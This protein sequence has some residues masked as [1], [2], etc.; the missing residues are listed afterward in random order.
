MEEK[1]SHQDAEIIPDDDAGGPEAAARMK[2]LRLELER[3]ETEKKDYL[4]GWQR[5]KADLANYKKDESRRFEEFSKFAAEGVIAEA[6]QVLDSFDLALAYEMP[7]EVER[8][9]VLIRSQLE[10]ILRRR[11][12]EVIQARGERFDPAY[13]ESVGEVESEGEPGMVAE[14]LQRGYLLGGRVL[15]PARVKVSK[16]AK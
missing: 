8:G 9:I 1:P 12:L 7:K 3:C 4:D 16:H 10:D 11:G 15:R 14:E 2:K 6:V 13:H 5:A